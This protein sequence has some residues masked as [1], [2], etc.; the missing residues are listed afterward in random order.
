MHSYYTIYCISE[1]VLR[2][3]WFIR[4]N[5]YTYIIEN[6]EKYTS[7]LFNTVYLYKY[8]RVASPFT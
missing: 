4:L 6:N 3:M 2:F 8:G 5:K 1:A 7:S